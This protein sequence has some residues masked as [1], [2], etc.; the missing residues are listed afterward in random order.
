MAVGYTLGYLAGDRY[1][2]FLGLSVMAIIAAMSNGN[3]GLYAALTGQYG[4]RSD[5][6]AISV[7]SLN[8]GPF[9]TM[10]A[11]GIL[12][13]SFPAAAFIGVLVPMLLGFILG[14]L[15]PDMRKFLAAGEV[16]V[17]PFFAFAL[18]AAYMNLA[19]FLRADVLLAGLLLAVLTVVVGGLS[20]AAMLRLF[21]ERSQTGGVAEASTAGN[22]GGTPAAIA[23]VA[24]GTGGE[25]YRSIVATAQ[26]QIS[27]STIT[28]ALLCPL[29][30]ILWDRWQ[31]SRGIDGKLEHPGRGGAYAE[32]DAPRPPLDAELERAYEHSPTD[33]PVK[34]RE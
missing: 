32:A 3:G 27:I 33:V 2:G 8:D 18:G 16:L 13:E 26:A 31:R 6:G 15:D 1:D 4:N 34:R 12:G 9:L 11:L 24:G 21:G 19:D 20:M 28:T 17:I 14:Q 5:V 25:A 29:A 22:A 10:I 7:I 30:V 23:L